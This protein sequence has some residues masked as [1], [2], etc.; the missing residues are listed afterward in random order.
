MI[1]GLFKLVFRLLALAGLAGALLVMAMRAKYPPVVEAMSRF[2]R[3]VVNPEAM[4]T[5]GQPGADAAVV[6][7]RG[8]TSGREY[9]TPVMAVPVDD[10]FVIPLALGTDADWYKN[11]EAAGGAVIVSEGETVDV[12]S[13]EIIDATAAQAFVP[14]D[15]QK[16]AS[17]FGVEDYLKLHAASKDNVGSSV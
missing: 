4:K 5:A 9:E 7:H 17:F 3:D 1:K 14:E 8:R 11:V 13:P 2:F 15:A 6:R 10:G 12:D 16:M